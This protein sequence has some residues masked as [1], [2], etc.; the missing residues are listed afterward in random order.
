MI[1]LSSVKSGQSLTVNISNTVLEESWNVC[2][3]S[4][5]FGQTK[6]LVLDASKPLSPD[7]MLSEREELSHD[8]QM[9]H[10]CN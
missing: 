7:G 3:T 4:K 5:S 2:G 1:A 9:L 8:V 10:S 6:V